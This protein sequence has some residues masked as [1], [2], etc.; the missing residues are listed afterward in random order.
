MHRCSVKLPFNARSR[1][2][3]DRMKMFLKVPAIEK[4]TTIT[5]LLLF[6]NLLSWLRSTSPACLRTCTSTHLLQDQSTMVD[7]DMEHTIM[8]NLWWRNQPEGYS[9]TYNNTNILSTP[10][11]YPYHHYH[12]E[13]EEVKHINSWMQVNVSRSCGTHNNDIFY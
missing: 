8:C 3:R 10:S 2:S 1:W 7:D 5:L 6:L 9:I 4:T 13:T 12:Q 11:Q